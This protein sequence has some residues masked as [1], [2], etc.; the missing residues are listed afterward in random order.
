MGKISQ[1]KILKSLQ[2]KDI[3]IAG[4]EAG[5][6]TKRGVNNISGQE[7]KSLI[8]KELSRAIGQEKKH[9]ILKKTFGFSE[10]K[11]K[12]ILL[13]A[14][15]V[16]DGK[17]QKVPAYIIK[18]ATDVSGLESDIRRARRSSLGI[19]NQGEKKLSA[20]ENKSTGFARQKGLNSFAGGVKPASPSKASGGARPLGL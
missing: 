7:A 3:K 20:L 1:Q 6:L 13:A 16:K 14:E 18:K 15:G 19:V 8:A 12:K 2:G 4:R 9:E 17:D 11:R 5:I 10:E